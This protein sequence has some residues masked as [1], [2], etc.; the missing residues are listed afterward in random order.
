M[1][2]PSQ[3]PARSSVWEPLGGRQKCTSSLASRPSAWK[4]YHG[5][6]RHKDGHPSDPGG[7]QVMSRSD[8]AW[9][10]SVDARSNSS[11]EIAQRVQER[12]EWV[13]YP[14]AVTRC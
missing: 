12:V 6:G 8:Y 4:I 3:D 5:K 13:A 9:I 2:S 14:G 1:F 7:V 10:F 11:V